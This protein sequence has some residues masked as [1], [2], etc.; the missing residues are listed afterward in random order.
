M[1][2]I[3]LH[4]IT[5]KYELQEL[6]KVFLSPDMFVS[7]T[8]AEAEAAADLEV[9]YGNG[10]SRQAGRSQ[11]KSRR[12]PRSQSCLRSIKSCPRIKTRSNE[13]FTVN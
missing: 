1:Y 4:G 5:N 2:K 10:I 11:R 8:D 3:L 6:I 9:K 12:L 7:Y 13:K